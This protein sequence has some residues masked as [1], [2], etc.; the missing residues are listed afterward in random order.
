MF[1][2]TIAAVVLVTGIGGTYGH[3]TKAE[4]QYVQTPLK[5]ETME[6]CTIARNLIFYSTAK[7]YGRPQ[8]VLGD[9]DVTECEEVK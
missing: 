1:S 8:Q 2:F 4:F 5:F 9:A 6:E 3:I 7:Y